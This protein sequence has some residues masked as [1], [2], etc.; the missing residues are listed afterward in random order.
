[1]IVTIVLY[2][3][4]QGEQDVLCVVIGCGWMDE[5][6]RRSSSHPDGKEE[7]SLDKNKR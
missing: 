2:D 6:R 1:M 5:V 3:K 4:N 7:S